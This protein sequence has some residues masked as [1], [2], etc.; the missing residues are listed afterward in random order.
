MLH[1]TTVQFLLLDYPMTRNITV[2]TRCTMNMVIGLKYKCI[3]LFIKAYFILF[4]N[5]FD[6]SACS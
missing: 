3:K 1:I 4:L 5:H 2:L 6:L